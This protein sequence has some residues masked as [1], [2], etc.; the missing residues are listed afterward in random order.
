MLFK[1]SL[2]RKLSLPVALA[3][4]FTFL[5][6]SALVL[7][8]AKKE[9]EPWE[10]AQETEVWEPVP[11]V[12]SAQP[13]QP[14]SDAVVLFDGKNLNAWSN[15]EGKAAGWKVE[16]G[17]V[18]VVP[19]TGDIRTKESFCDIQLH[20][21]WR[22]PAKIAGKEGQGLGNSGVFLQERYEIQVLDSY[23]N[24]TYPNGQATSVYK[25]V[26]PLVNATRAPG[27][28]QTYDIIYKAPVF[29]NSEK[30]VSPAYV[31]VLHNGVLVQNHTEI[32]GPTEWIGKHP[33]KAH[34]CAPLRLQ[35]HGDLVSFRNIW[36]R[37][38]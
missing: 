19:K 4:G 31:T 14:P 21:E 7:A 35:D 24:P 30:L 36:V 11:P 2:Y 12:V 32:E 29:D 10:Q 5:L 37:K 8:E 28:W 27:E 13:N 18:T 26:I 17:A 34:D 23:E 20:L 9:K 16:N 22:S 38:L 25:Q 3:G 33:Y 1:S 15:L 6:S